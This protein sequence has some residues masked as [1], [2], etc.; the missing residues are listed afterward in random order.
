M[1]SQFYSS[2][3]DSLSSSVHLS[4]EYVLKLSIYF[5]SNLISFVLSLRLLVFFPGDQIKKNELAWACGK[6][7]GEES[8]MQ[9]SGEEIWGETPI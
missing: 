7:G 5:S 3:T 6:Y 8:S 4:D 9:D 2:V 1:S